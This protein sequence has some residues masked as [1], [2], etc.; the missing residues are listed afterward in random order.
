MPRGSAAARRVQAAL[1]PNT[2]NGGPAEQ[3][4]LQGW[5]GE[6]KLGMGSNESVQDVMGVTWRGCRNLRDWSQA[7]RD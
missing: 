2:V 3:L 5:E 1:F 7:L 4:P 6:Y